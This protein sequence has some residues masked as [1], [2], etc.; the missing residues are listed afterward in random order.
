MCQDNLGKVDSRSVRLSTSSLFVSRLFTN[1]GASTSHNLIDLHGLSEGKFN[2]VSNLR[3]KPS[4]GSR[5][6]GVWTDNPAL[7]NLRI[8]VDVSQ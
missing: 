8:K 7:D 3:I 6:T 1:V 5:E 2:L 4:S